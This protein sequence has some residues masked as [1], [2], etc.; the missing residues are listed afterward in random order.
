MPHT[1]LSLVTFSKFH[2]VSYFFN[3]C[4]EQVYDQAA[5]LGDLLQ[6]PVIYASPPSPT[7]YV[8]GDRE[9]SAVHSNTNR[10]VSN[11]EIADWMVEE[12]EE[13]EEADSISS[14]LPQ[15]QIQVEKTLFGNLSDYTVMASH[16]WIDGIRDPSSGRYLPGHT[17]FLY[18][19]KKP[20]LGVGIKEK[21]EGA[22][23]M[24]G[25]PL[26][27]LESM[28]AKGLSK[29]QPAA[30]KPSEEKEKEK[31]SKDSVETILTTQFEQTAGAGIAR[32]AAA[33]SVTMTAPAISD[34]TDE[35]ED[36]DDFFGAAST[37]TAYK[38]RPVQKSSTA[39]A[40]S[41]T[42]S[43]SSSVPL[44]SPKVPQ[45]AIN[46]E[47]AVEVAVAVEPPTA[48]EI[49]DKRKSKKQRVVSVQARLAERQRFLSEAQQRRQ[50]ATSEIN[51]QKEQQVMEY[52]L[53]KG[54][55][56]SRT[57][58]AQE[59]SPAR[60]RDMERDYRESK[61]K[62]A[63]VVTFTPTVAVESDDDDDDSDGLWA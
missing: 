50:T 51:K 53:R 18:I 24:G 57:P 12:E 27:S 43:S 15:V 37:M 62:V 47:E 8:M 56:L 7:L 60:D 61:G 19:I 34:D 2:D 13:E 48:E 33:A 55:Q 58:S 45:N 63:D 30:I 25:R 32:T 39:A 11:Y 23:T 49:E 26:G 59:A 44:P 38:R 35:A 3:Y 42:D 31:K 4:D 9:I 17:P 29:L 6:V 14:S 54:Y 41:A 40:V 21:E 20:P 52:Q 46:G 36:E 22:L 28:V 10:Q 5:L 1:L 16:V